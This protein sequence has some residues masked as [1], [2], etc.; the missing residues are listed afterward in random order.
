M[1]A[2]TL[3]LESQEVVS[4]HNGS[5]ELNS[6]PLEEQVCGFVFV[7]VFVFVFLRCLGYFGFWW[8]WPEECKTGFLC[9]ALAI[10]ELTLFPT[11]LEACGT[12]LWLKQVHPVANNVPLGPIQKLSVIFWDRRWLSD[13]E[14]ILSLQRT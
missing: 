14:H 3:E 6:G 9:V 5:W 8:E 4:H 12:T 10:L 11:W 7:F 13:E 1:Y 2:G